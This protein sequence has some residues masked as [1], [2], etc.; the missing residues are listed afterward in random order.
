MKNIEII[1]NIKN[2]EVVRVVVDG[3]LCNR[4]CSENIEGECFV[5]GS[6]PLKKFDAR[7]Y[8]RCFKCLTAEKLSLLNGKEEQLV[9]DIIKVLES[10]G[11][12]QEDWKPPIENRW[13]LEKFLFPSGCTEAHFLRDEIESKKEQCRTTHKLSRF[14]PEVLDL[15]MRGRT[16]HQVL[17]VGAIKVYQYVDDTRFNDAGIHRRSGIASRIQISKIVQ[18]KDLRNLKTTE[19]EVKIVGLV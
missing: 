8:F 11:H 18:E 17:L 19:R 5:F 9:R 4:M 7:N 2:N 14:D 3:P 15:E 16:P 1:Q 6:E 13:I 12:V 10:T